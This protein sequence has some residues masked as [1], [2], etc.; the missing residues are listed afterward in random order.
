MKIIR[1]I[2][3][4]A[5]FAAITAA[6]V[7][8]QAKPGT[9]PP[10]T[11]AKP[12]ASAPATTGGSATGNVPDTKLA[13]V[14]TDAFLDPKA[15]I[16]RLVAAANKVEALF[17]PRR[18]E[19]QN[20]QAQVD[21]MTTDLQKTAAVQ[22]PKV[23]AQKQDAIDQKKREITRKTEDAQ[24]AYQKALQD[25]LGPVYDDI[26]K[27]LDAFAKAH[28]ITL[29]LDVTKVQGIVSADGSLDITKAFITAFNSKNPATASL[30][31]QP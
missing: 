17:Q 16:M 29:I 26:G 9:T 14:D 12:P 31:P 22:D 23:T 18:A 10:V 20:L 1:A 15:G 7:A 3:A 13:L 4:I 5:F 19:L 2:A 24:S 6:S 21:Q 8:A 30:T 28:G 27:E 25:Q 11:Q